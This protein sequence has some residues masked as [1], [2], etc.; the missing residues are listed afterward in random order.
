MKTF[1]LTLVAII[2]LST[3]SFSQEANTATAQSKTQLTSAKESGMY[4]FVMPSTLTAED[5]TKNSKYYVH[6]F[7]TEFNE[8][9]KEVKMKM[10]T[11]DELSRHVITRFLAA[12]GVQNVIVD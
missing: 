8:T 6:Y 5:V 12:C 9:T 2:G 10:V 11:N 7:S 4:T 1:F 3:V